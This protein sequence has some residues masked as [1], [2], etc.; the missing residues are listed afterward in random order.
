MIGMAV[1]DEHANER[2]AREGA[3][4]RRDVRAE[5]DARIDER[6]PGAVDEPGVVAP[7]GHRARIAGRDEQRGHDLGV[8]V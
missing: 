1:R 7:A 2:P 4:D 6:G 8:L 5:A 3:V